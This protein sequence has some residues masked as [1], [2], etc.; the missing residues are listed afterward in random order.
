MI[1]E[2]RQEKLSVVYQAFSERWLSFLFPEQGTKGTGVCK[3]GSVRLEMN[4]N[5]SKG[6]ALVRKQCSAFIQ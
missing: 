3:R 5:T 2:L 4:A 6:A 1:S